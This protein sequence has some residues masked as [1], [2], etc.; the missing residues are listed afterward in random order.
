MSNH[1]LHPLPDLASCRMS[2]NGALAAVSARFGT[3][4]RISV[5]VHT[6][7]PRGLQLAK[8]ERKGGP[9]R[10]ELAQEISPGG[11]RGLI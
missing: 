5:S 6:S 8:I 3:G 2:P 9:F 10:A 7:N 1:F 4:R 11:P